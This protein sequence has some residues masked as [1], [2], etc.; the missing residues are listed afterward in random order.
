MTS[1]RCDKCA[2]E[3]S[4]SASVCP[5]CGTPLKPAVQRVLPS[6]KAVFTRNLVVFVGIGVGCLL[7]GLFLVPWI[8]SREV[9]NITAT[10]NQ[11]TQVAN[12]GEITAKAERGDAG[13]QKQLGACCARGQGVPQSYE[14]AAKWYRRAAEQGHAA[15][16]TALAQLYEAGRGVP[17]DSELAAKWYRRAAEL[18]DAVGQYNLAVLYVMGDGVPQDNA[19]AMRWYRRAA[20][21]G[22]AMAQ[23]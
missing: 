3:V 17:H 23:Y 4:E 16:Q 18:G 21:Q 20:A 6:R 7:A 8:A 1:K 13:A 9:A 10:T 19:E 12:L 14:E 5:A 11:T 22:S 2:G 15:A